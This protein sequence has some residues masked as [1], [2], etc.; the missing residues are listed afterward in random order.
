MSGF[1]IFMR[2]LT[3]EL[4]NP[5]IYVIGLFVGVLINLLQSG[6]AFYSLVPFIVPVHGSAT[7]TGTARNSCPSR[8]NVMSPRSSVM[9]MGESW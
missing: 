8:R 1:A 3:K 9:M 7:G 2:C 6:M 5:V 4:I